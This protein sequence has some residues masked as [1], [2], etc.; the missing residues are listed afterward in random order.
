MVGDIPEGILRALES[1]YGELHIVTNEGDELVEV[2]SSEWYKA[3][4]SS[5]TP[6]KVLRVYRERAGM[7]Q[8]ALGNKIGNVPRQHIS[9]METGR[10]PIGKE[11]AKKLAVVLN[12]SPLKFI[13]I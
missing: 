8:G 9:G 1:E 7:T 6:G 12:T 13:D 10:R 4:H 5:I 11:M 2:T 3:I